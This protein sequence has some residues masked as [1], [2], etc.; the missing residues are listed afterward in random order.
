[1]GEPNQRVFDRP[2]VV[3]FYAGHDHL[4][5]GESAVLADI[6]RDLPSMAVLDIGIGGGRTTV[7]LAPRARRYAGIDY[8]PRMI[9]AAR[10]RFAKESWTL[11]VA[12]ARR[13]PYPTSSFDFALFSYC[14]IDYVSHSDRQKVLAEV[15][16]VLVSGGLF[17]FSTHNLQRARELFYG[18]PSES[19]LKRLLAA[20]RRRRLRRVNP[21]I[22]EL[23]SAP[24]AVINDGA[25]RFAA[26]TYHIRPRAQ[27]E[28]LVEAGF[29]DVRVYSAANGRVLAGE[30]VDASTEPWLMYL[31]KK[32]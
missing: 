26:T 23:E 27:M 12:D 22:E 19:T 24:F 1:M 20:V 8:A 11:D 3:R 29:D 4:Q 6:E 32:V 17:A 31:A 14:G 5:A 16:R 9:A 25:F 18:C 10:R 7:H 28:Q 2:D 30:Q 15:K 21:K 13:V